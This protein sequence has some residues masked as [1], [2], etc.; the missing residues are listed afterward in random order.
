MLQVLIGD[1][2]HR[3]FGDVKLTFLNAYTRFENL[4]PED[5]GPPNS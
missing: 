4:A 5:A 2:L 1:L 3:N